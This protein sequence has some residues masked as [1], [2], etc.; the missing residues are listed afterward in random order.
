MRYPLQWTR[1]LNGL[2]NSFTSKK[3]PTL[4]IVIKILSTVRCF[5]FRADISVSGC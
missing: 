4:F 5:L 3:N 1:D 2:F